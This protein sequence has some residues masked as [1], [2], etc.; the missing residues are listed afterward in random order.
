MKCPTTILY[1][2]ASTNQ[3]VTIKE[4]SK[5]NFLVDCRPRKLVIF[6]KFLSVTQGPTVF[7]SQG[8]DTI[9]EKSLSKKK[10]DPFK[11]WLSIKNQ[12]F[13]SNPYEIW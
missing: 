5:V 11:N 6:F 9:M 1:L 4:I 13:L 12:Q 2:P 8:F 7:T 3:I 10:R